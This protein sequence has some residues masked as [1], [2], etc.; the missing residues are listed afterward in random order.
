VVASPALNDENPAW[1]VP[2]SQEAMLIEIALI[3]SQDS[4][5][6]SRRNSS[7]VALS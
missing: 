6:I 7:Y 3:S 4:D 2:G 5:R 1:W